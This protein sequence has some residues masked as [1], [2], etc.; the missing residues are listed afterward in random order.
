M[1]CLILISSRTVVQ[2]VPEPRLGAGRETETA[3]HPHHVH[4]RPAE[5]VGAR[6]PGDSLSGHLYTR[7]DRHEDR[8]DRGPCPGKYSYRPN[9]FESGTGRMQWEYCIK[10]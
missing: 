5:G 2:S 7:G 1:F 6:L 3:T 8:L 9:T 4:V 10:H